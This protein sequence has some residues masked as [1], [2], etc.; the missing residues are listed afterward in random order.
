MAQPTD[1]N[2]DFTELWIGKVPTVGAVARAGYSH[3]NAQLFRVF[4]PVGPFN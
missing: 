2:G 4:I 1:T 3:E